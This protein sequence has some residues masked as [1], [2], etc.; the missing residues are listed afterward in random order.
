MC[1]LAGIIDAE[2]PVS[3]GLL[4]K[5]GQCLAHRGPDGQKIFLSHF[6]ECGF[7]HRRLAI[8]DPQTRSDQPFTS[9]DGRYTIVFNGEIFNFLELRAKLTV[10]GHTFL[11]ESDTEVLLHSYIAWGARMLTMLNGMWALAIWD[12]TEKCLF[13][14]RDRFGVKPLLYASKG[15]RF[16]FGSEVRSLLEIPWVDRA[17]RLEVARRLL[18][19]PMSIEGSEYTLHEGIRRLPGGHYATLR[20]GQLLVTRWW[21]TAENLPQAIPKRFDEAAERFR[22][23]FIDAVRL[24]MRSDVP[25]ASCLS[26]GFDSSAVVSTMALVSRQQEKLHRV[27]GDWRHAFVATFR[28]HDHDESEMAKLAAQHA[29]VIPHFFDLGTDDGEEFVE[30]VLDALDDVYISLPTAPFR[31]Y[32]EVRAA[33][34][35][36]TL[37]GHGADEMIG[38]YR[39]GSQLAT[40]LYRNALGDKAGGRWQSWLADTAKLGF[41]HASQGIFLRGCLTTLQIDCP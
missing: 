7:V 29:G 2:H 33:G 31:I 19:D 5:V 18:F 4:E 10:L 17:P 27:S 22:E 39:N 12:E 23:L 16:A 30:H 15:R 32:Q 11:T 3:I 6:R 21:I 34:V 38:G 26:G 13:L 28:G 20:K 37:D 41:L 35:C 14:A 24:R 36:V 1:G 25:I 40:F 9:S 8:L